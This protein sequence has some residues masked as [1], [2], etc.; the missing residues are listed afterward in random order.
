MRKKQLL[1]FFAFAIELTILS[2]FVEKNA[3]E[4][5][6]LKYKFKKIKILVGLD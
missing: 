3:L 2:V 6:E 1:I 5:E 4:V